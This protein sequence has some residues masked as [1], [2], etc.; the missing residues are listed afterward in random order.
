MLNERMLE[1]AVDIGDRA[2][3]LLTWL[4]GAVESGF[5]SLEHAGRYVGD[6]EAAEGWLAKHFHDLPEN[7][8]PLAQVGPQLRRFAN[9]FSTYLR[10]SFDLHEVPGTRFDLG[11]D[12]YCC[13][14][15]GYQCPWR[16]SSQRSSGGETGKRRVF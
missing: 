13:E 10:S 1:E 15:C 9:Y 16:I 6:Q 11:G 3:R 12:P 7:A 4:N 5:I 2:Y 14:W 8:R